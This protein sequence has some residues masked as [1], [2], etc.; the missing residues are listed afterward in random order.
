MDDLSPTSF[1][2]GVVIWIFQIA[3]LAL[4]HGEPKAK[5]W[6]P[7]KQRL[8]SAVLIALPIFVVS[9]RADFDMQ[10][11]YGM[12]A[13]PCFFAGLYSLFDFGLSRSLSH[14]VSEGFGVGLVSSA[15]S[16]VMSL[17]HRGVTWN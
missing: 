17:L 5:T 3:G 4:F 15:P 9:R 10:L 14:A 1:A 11:I 12:F 6:P 16:I 2:N 7:I 13:M 8:A